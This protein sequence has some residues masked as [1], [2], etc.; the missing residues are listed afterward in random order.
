MA[1]VVAAA[2][3]A[4]SVGVPG[5]GASWVVWEAASVTV[6]VA[7]YSLH[8]SAV[9][10]WGLAWLAETAIAAAGWALGWGHWRS[11]SDVQPEP[12]GRILDDPWAARLPGFLV[13][14][15]LPRVHG[16]W[17]AEGAAWPGQRRAAACGWSWSSR[18]WLQKTVGIRRTRSTR[19]NVVR[20]RRMQ[21]HGGR[22]GASAATTGVEARLSARIVPMGCARAKGVVQPW[23]CHSGSPTRFGCRD[24]AEVAAPWASQAAK[25]QQEWPELAPGRSKRRQLPVCEPQRLAVKA[26][27]AAAASCE[28]ARRL[29]HC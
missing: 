12:T 7:E 21:S 16:A 8:S 22:W 25:A 2:A 11:G 20:P 18:C 14:R 5:A 9:T 28:Q 27:E 29:S 24:E 23:H 13:A 10:A 6:L 4:A 15:R 17:A 19:W 26:G 1:A 3:A